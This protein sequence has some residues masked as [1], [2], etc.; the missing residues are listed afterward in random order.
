MK[1][2]LIVV[3]YQNDFVTGSLGFEKARMIEGLIADKIK[4]YKNSGDEVCFTLDTHYDN[5]LST[6][7]GI[8]LPFV[9]CVKG[10]QGHK[11]FGKV[12]ELKE[13]TDKCFEKETFGSKELFEYLADKKYESVELCGVVTNICII[14]NAVLVKIALPETPVFVDA[15]CVASNDDNLGFSALKVMESLHINIINK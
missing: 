10:T 8:H 6:Q 1:K 9:H 14:S 3:D 13:N 4:E 11:L 5:Y 7:E 15:K 12:A 2:L